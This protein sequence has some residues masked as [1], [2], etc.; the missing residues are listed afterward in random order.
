[1]PLIW[2]QGSPLAFD[3]VWL[4]M[5]DTFQARLENAMK[6]VIVQAVEDAKRFTET[7]PSAKSGKSGRVESGKMVEQIIGRSYREGTRRVIGEFGFLNGPAELY[8]ALQTV[9]GFKHWLSG[10]FIEP[11]FAFRDAARIALQNLYAEMKG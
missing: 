3:R 10:D 5:L 11:T 9:T 2:E 1:M 8:M 7:R 4:L 6:K